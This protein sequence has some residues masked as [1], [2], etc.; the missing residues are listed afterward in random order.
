MQWP[1]TRKPAPAAVD[2]TVPEPTPGRRLT[3]AALIGAR[4][5][6]TDN[7]YAAARPRAGV[8]PAGMA[9]DFDPS[10]G[11][12]YSASALYGQLHEGIGFLGYAYLSQLA[13]RPEYRS[14]VE[15]KAKE[16]TRKGFRLTASGDDKTDLVERM[17]QVCKEFDV[18]GLLRRVAE[19]DG[20]FGV[21]HIYVDT[22]IPSENVETPLILKPAKIKQ[23]GDLQFRTIEPFWLYPGVYNTQSP[24]DRDF[25]RPQV[26]YCQGRSIHTSRLLT[27]VAREMPDMLKPA[28]AFG[29]L[30]LTQMAKPY[31]DNWLRARQS[32]SDLLHSFSVPVLMTVMGNVL[33]GIAGAMAS[34]LTRVQAFNQFRDNRGTFVLDKETED[35]KTVTTPLSGVDKL[36]AQAQEQI[37]SVVGIPLVVLLGVTPSGLN[38][39]SD[40][41]V[42]TFYARIKAEQEQFFRPHL[43]TILTILQLWE[44]GTVDDSLDFQFNDLWETSELDGSTVRKNVADTDAVY[45]NAGVVDPEEVRARL[46]GDDES[47]Y[48]GLAGPAPEPPAAPAEGPP[49]EQDDEPEGGE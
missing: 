32:V 8:A 38:A 10:A 27:F 42:R 14:I 30:A 20:F 5:P 16:M 17:E 43:K 34:L 39:S 48:H 47:I 37:A 46:A 3:A 33:S 36:Q 41:E 7:P 49:G 15:I 21:A 6:G 18:I 24:L 28:Y 31:V 11:G 45:I 35:F 23:N 9:M 29:G 1:W 19:L 13:Q 4:P 44:N 40:G 12:A 26:W 2:I 25:Y 22:G